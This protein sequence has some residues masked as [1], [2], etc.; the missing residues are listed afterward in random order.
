MDE[1][2]AGPSA[3]HWADVGR[4]WP[5][6]NCAQAIGGWCQ[7]KPRPLHTGLYAAYKLCMCDLG[8]VFVTWTE[9]GHGH[10]SHDCTLAQTNSVS[11]VC[12]SVWSWGAWPHSVLY[13]VRQWVH[14]SLWQ[15]SNPSVCS[16]LFMFLFK[17]LTETVT[18][19]HWNYTRNFT[20][21]ISAVDCFGVWWYWHTG[22]QGLVGHCY[23]LWSQTKPK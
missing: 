21:W 18:N 15:C 1:G 12:A 3:R 22:M 5:A 7:P 20:P 9:W 16:C 8:P 4:S 11:V 10:A 2:G 14:V 17:W 23:A 19:A 13:F 6:H